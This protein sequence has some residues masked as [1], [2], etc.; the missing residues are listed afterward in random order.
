ME[1]N[2]GRDVIA[3]WLALQVRQ[4][5]ALAAVVEE[6]SFSRAAERLGYTQSAVSQQI[7]ALE[8]VVGERL[9]VRP[10]R[11]SPLALTPAGRI[12]LSYAQEAIGRL[13]VMTAELGALKNGKAGLLRLGVFQSVGASI[14]PTLL[15]RFAKTSVGV[16]LQ[17]QEAVADPE[18]FRSVETG[19]LD[20]AFAIFPLPDG[21][22]EGEQLFVDHYQLVVRKDSRLASRARIALADLHRLPIVCF[23]RCRGTDD[24]LEQLRARGVSPDLV[25]RTDDNGTVIG[26]VR[27]GLGAGLL[28]RLSLSTYDLRRDLV[29]RPLEPAELVRRVGLAW[30]RAATPSGPAA[31]FLSLCRATLPAGEEPRWGAV[32]QAL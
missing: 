6:Q 20:L 32:A 3:P 4:L 12:V 2:T 23:R 17:V 28:P 24:A 31:E 22:F 27:A 10:E 30:H 13:R 29:A 7:A 16:D 18:L 8:R 25:F 15:R 21:P 14:L 5:A 26:L 11:A 19:D 9:L 1:L